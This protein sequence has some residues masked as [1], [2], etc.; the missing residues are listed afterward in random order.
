ME[1]GAAEGGLTMPTENHMS[2]EDSIK[3]LEEHGQLC[4]VCRYDDCCNHGVV[5]GPNGPIFPPCCDKDIRDL[6]YE[7]DA[8]EQAE[9]ICNDV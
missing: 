1:D 2:F 4:S 6:L 7:D 8:I 5:G 9:E 3:V